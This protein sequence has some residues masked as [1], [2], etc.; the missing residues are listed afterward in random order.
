MGL[1]P[2][3]VA[4]D[5]APSGGLGTTAR[6]VA[7]GLSGPPLAVTA[8]V[9]AQT[10]RTRCRRNAASNICFRAAM[11]LP[12]CVM[13]TR[14]CRKAG[15]FGTLADPMAWIA[16]PIPDKGTSGGDWNLTEREQQ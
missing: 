7:Q 10:R 5:L 14:I 2:L 13:K 1:A 4:T 15:A 11:V 9:D 8:R 12:H 6:P 16:V 3:V